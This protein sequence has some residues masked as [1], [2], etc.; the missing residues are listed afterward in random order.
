MRHQ[1]IL[2]AFCLRLNKLNVVFFL[3]SIHS[4]S[5]KVRKM[6]KAI[7]TKIQIFY[8]YNKEIFQRFAL[9]SSQ[10]INW[11]KRLSF[12]EISTKSN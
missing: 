8:G 4:Y 1:R 3:Q 7:G 5:F 2:C 9:I 10:N 12:L 11:P 6:S